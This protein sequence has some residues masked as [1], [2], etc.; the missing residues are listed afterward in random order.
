M[1]SRR[2]EA[3]CEPGAAHSR[4]PDR[5]RS[6]EGD[7]GIESR[8]TARTARRSADPG[9]VSPWRSRFGSC[10]GAL[11]PGRSKTGA[12]PCEPAEERRAEHA[13]AATI[14]ATRAPATAA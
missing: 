12:A 4:T 11:G 7:Q 6:R 3:S 8:R 13:S 14:E 1:E 5:E 9:D 10:G 2:T